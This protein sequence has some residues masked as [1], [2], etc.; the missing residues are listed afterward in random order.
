VQPLAVFS[1]DAGEAPDGRDEV[2]VARGSVKP[3]YDAI[4]NG[5]GYA[6][7]ATSI[8]VDN[9]PYFAQYD[10]VLNTRTGELI[11]VTACPRTR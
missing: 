6:S 7:G 10:H 3:R 9:G 4:N 8:V 5:A 2:L 11:R 1:R